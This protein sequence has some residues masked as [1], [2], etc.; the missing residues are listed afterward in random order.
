AFEGTGFRRAN[1]HDSTR[2]PYED[3]KK[4]SSSCRAS[5]RPQP[6]K[7]M[8]PVMYDSDVI[9]VGG[10]AGGATFAYACARPGK[11]VLLLERGRRYVPEKSA[12]DEQAM[13]IEKRPYDD[14]EVEINGARKRLYMGGVLGGGTAL[15]GAALL[16]PSKDDFHPGKHYGDRIPRALWDWPIPYDHLEPYYAEAERLYGV[17]GCAG[18]DF[19]PLQRPDSFPKPPLPLH[20]INRKLMS[21]NRA[22]GLRPFRLPLAI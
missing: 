8:S 11:S 1:Q 6:S 21:A 16:R 3:G 15:Y 2:M 9:V 18:E 20:P 12:L 22:G 14:R 10:G 19:G 7:V 17:A 5:F 13:L 4:F